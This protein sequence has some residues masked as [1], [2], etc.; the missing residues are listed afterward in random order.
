MTITGIV[1]AKHDGHAHK[2]LM[3]MVSEGILDHFEL[4]GF[5]AE[6]EDVDDFGA[7]VDMDGYLTLAEDHPASLSEIIYQKGILYIFEAEY[8]G[9]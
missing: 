7:Y 5:T 8:V 2:I 4:T 3:E 1:D 6:K 9:A